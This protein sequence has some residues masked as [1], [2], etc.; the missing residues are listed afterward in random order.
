MKKLIIIVFI[1]GAYSFEVEK[2]KL[3][4]QI[5]Y[6]QNDINPRLAGLCALF[7]TMGHLYVNKWDRIKPINSL[8]ISPVISVI[9]LNPNEYLKDERTF[10]NNILIP[11]KL[12]WYILQIQDAI[13]L[14]NQHNANLYK[15]IYEEEYITTPK[16]SIIQK[17]IEK[18]ESK[19][20]NS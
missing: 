1:V 11:P 5:L 20:D 8:I 7:P 14:A 3:D 10:I 19:Q 13:F 4:K 9:L 6:E 18:Q 12:I 2:N 16:K 15:E 17:L